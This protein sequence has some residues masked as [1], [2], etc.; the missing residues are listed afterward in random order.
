MNR[1]FGDFDDDDFTPKTEK[2]DADYLMFFPN[3]TTIED[4]EDEL[5]HY[6]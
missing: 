1:R 3:A 5:E 2:I 4:I 6:M